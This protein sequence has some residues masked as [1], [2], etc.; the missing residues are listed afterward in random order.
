MPDFQTALALA[1]RGFKVFPITPGAKSPPLWD[2]WPQRATAAVPT[3]W[4]TGANVGIHCAG[5]VVIDVDPRKGGSETLAAIEVETPGLPATLTSRTPSGGNHYF[6]RLPEGHPGVPNRVNAFGDGIDIRST[7]GYVVGAGSTTPQGAYSWLYD[8]PI[9][10]APLWLLDA[11]GKPRERSADAGTRVPDADEATVER[12][13]TW[14][15]ARPGAVEGQGGDAFTF[16]TAA[17]LRDFGVSAKQAFELMA[18]WNAKC[19]PPWGEDD[20]WAKVENAYRYAGGAAGAKA[21]SADDFPLIEPSAVP[22][23]IPAAPP[24]VDR[25][26]PVAMRDVARGPAT[27]ASYIIK[28]LLMRRSYAMIYGPPGEGKTFVGLDMAYHVAMGLEWMGR[29]VRQGDALYVGFE[30]YGGLANRVLALRGKYGADAP[31]YIVGGGFDL[32]QLEGRQ[33]FGQ[34]LAALPNKPALIV[35]DTFAYALAGGD[36]NSAQDVGSFNSAVQ[37][38]IENTGA[39]VLLIH[40]T[41]KDTN[42]GARGSSALPA[43]IDTEIAILDRTLTSTKQRETELGAPIGFQL[44]PV[45]IGTD[46]DGDGIMSCV[47]DPATATPERPRAKKGNEERVLDELIRLSPNNEPVGYI[48]LLEACVY[49]LPD[50]DGRR[51]AAFRDVIVGLENKGLIART[52]EGMISRVM[53]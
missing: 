18:E 22:S 4:P 29:R 42:R 6:Y 27:A 40:H 21:V 1:S 20:L 26:V 16:G 17:F 9:A 52:K 41:G 3:D 53:T 24:R 43:A 47:V 19:S 48:N 49:F 33:A 10:D 37:G 7:G 11:L 32:R 35:Y 45:M 46:E 25:R 13:R 39:C 34:I 15:E 38:L 8:V 44:T 50:T 36:E 14:L 51:R 2:G 30:A 31:L 5:L 28:G 23:I 12:A